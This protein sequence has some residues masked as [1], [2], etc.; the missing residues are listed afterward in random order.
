MRFKTLTKEQEQELRN[1][2]LEIP[3]SSLSQKLK[4]TEGVI[5]RRLKMWGL[6]IPKEIKA[7][8]RKNS[9]FKK[10]HKPFNVGKKQEDYMSSEAIRKVK[11]TQFKKGSIPHNTNFDGHERITKDGYIEVRVSKRNYRLKHLHEWEK[12][13]GKL[14]KGHCLWCIDK[15][16]ENTSPDNWR[17]I[18]R[19]ENMLNNSHANYPKEI[20]PSLVLINKINNKIKNIEN[21]TK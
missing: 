1:N 8:H 7:K 21:G 6:E 16:K 5:Y 11:K 14:P 13:N 9:N 10:G 20:I 17:L 2:Y 18:S 12:I 15:N 19:I 3:I 4:L